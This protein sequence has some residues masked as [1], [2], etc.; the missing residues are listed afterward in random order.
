MYNNKDQQLA[1]I[2]SKYFEYKKEE[3]GKIIWKKIDIKNLPFIPI[4]ITT[5]ISKKEGQMIYTFSYK[6]PYSN[7]YI[8]TKYNDIFILNKNQ[9]IQLKTVNNNYEEDDELSIRL[10]N[11]HID[12]L[13]LASKRKYS[14]LEYITK[15]RNQIFSLNN[16]I[17]KP[18]TKRLKK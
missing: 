16:L 7:E 13:K 3:N 14:P 11:H 1:L 9:T 18:K 10:D 12:I 17:K 5:E 6:L 4:L 8:L 15:K 2:E